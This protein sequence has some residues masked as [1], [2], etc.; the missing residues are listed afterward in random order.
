MDSLKEDFEKNGFAIL[1]GFYSAQQ[2]DAVVDSIAKRKLERPMNVTIDLLDTGE[3]SLLGLLTPKEIET[4]RMKINDLYLDMTDVRELALSER[5]A[6]VLQQLFDQSPALCNSLYFEKGSQQPAHVDSI[7]MT[8]TTPDHLIAIWVALEDAHVDAGQLEYYPGSHKIEPM[9][10]SNGLRHFVPDEMP[11]W[12]A[13]IEEEVARRGFEKQV[14]S[15]KKGDVLIWHANLLHGGGPIA[16]PARTRKSLVFH[17]FSAQDATKL[18]MTLR[19]VSC[20][21]WIDRPIQQV[22][23]EAFDRARF[24]EA[25]LAKYPDVAQ[26]VKDNTFVSGTQHYQLFGKAEGR[27]V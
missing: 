12:H 18:E 9:I 22:P 16:D 17:Y 6:P 2:I 15:A 10:F 24:E 27:S 23:E 26:A 19:P 14:F 4:R 5:I 3:R 11:K 20:G 25:Y 7:Y 13:Y 21:F 1:P 8:P